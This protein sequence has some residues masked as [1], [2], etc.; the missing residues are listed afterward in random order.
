MPGHM[1]NGHMN[2]RNAV[3]KITDITIDVIQRE[4]GGTGLESD[5]GR[6]GGEVAQGV[7]RIT[8][9]EGVEGN[10]FVGDF[11]SG[12]AALFDPILKVLKPEL[13]GRDATAREWLWNRLGILGAR[14]GVTFPAWAPVDVALWDLAGK[15]AGMPVFRLL[16]ASRE[17]TEVYA[18]Y[19]PRHESAE[20]YVEEARDIAARGFRAYKIHP[21]MMSTADTTKAVQDVRTAVGDDMTLMLDPNNNYDFRKALTVGRALDANDFHWYEDPVPWDDFDS[22]VEL[23]RR[24]DTPLAMS[25]LAGYLF[26]E[27]A[28]YIRLGAPRILRATARKHGITGMRKIAGMAEAFGLNCEIGTAGNSLLNAANLHVIC[29]IANCD[30]YEWWMPAE[31]H[32]FGLVDHYGLNDRMMLDAPESPGLGCE[33]DEEWIAAHRVATLQ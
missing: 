14:R 19:P 12:G 25:D 16:G 18:T 8:T 30:Y 33:L 6:F 24:L 11:R 32:Q 1:N 31:A 26:R 28:H 20:G 2:K 15:A 13:L 27:P 9:N 3:L 4:V 10:C 5:L 7:L 22:I 29:S 17:E 23:T 21:G